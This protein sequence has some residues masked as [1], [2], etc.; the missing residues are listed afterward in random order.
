MRIGACLAL[1]AEPGE[2]EH[3][4]PT[5]NMPLGAEGTQFTKSSIVLLT[6][7]ESGLLA[8]VLVQAVVAIGAVPGPGERLAFG[9]AAQVVLVKV[10]ALE[11]L[12]AKALEEMFADQ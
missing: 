9:H 5:A 10:L 2:V 1:G 4:K 11:P 8:N 7:R 12:L 6:R 3:A